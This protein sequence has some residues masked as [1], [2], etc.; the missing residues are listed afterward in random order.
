MDVFESKPLRE[1]IA[2]RIRAD[3]IRGNYED[4]ER[5]VE[6]KLARI[7]GISRTPIREH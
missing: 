6:P 5:L 1:K 4:G 3:I 2:D 7:L